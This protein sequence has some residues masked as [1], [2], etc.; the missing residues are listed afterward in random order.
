MKLALIFLSVC[1]AISQQQYFHPRM[2]MGYPWMSPFAQHPMYF[3]NYMVSFKSS[4]Y[5]MKFHLIIVDFRA[6][7]LTWAT[8]TDMSMTLRPE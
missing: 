5:K 8:L 4:F 2:M 7:I 3:N 1:V 6:N